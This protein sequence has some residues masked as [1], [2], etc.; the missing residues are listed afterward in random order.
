MAMKI[1]LITDTHFNH[2]DK[3]A[4]YCQ[5]PLNYEGIVMSAI[6]LLPPDAVLVH[7]GDICIGNDER[8]NNALSIRCHCRRILVR[9]N[10]DKK[11]NQWYCNHGWDFVCEKFQDNIY[12]KIILFSHKPTA[13]NGEYDVNI[14]G[15]FHN[16]EHRQAEPELVAIKND[17]QRCLVLENVAYKPV[18]L[19]KWLVGGGSKSQGG[20]R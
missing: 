14:H 15:H 8:W 3:M 16:K 1:Y 7:L 19:E 5:R 13:D 4:E 12:G 2:V 20:Y 9:G 10:H 18:A 6:S 11:S 17:K